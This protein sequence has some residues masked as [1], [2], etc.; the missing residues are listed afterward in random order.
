MAIWRLPPAGSGVSAR[1]LTRRLA[2]EGCHEVLLESGPR[3]GSALLRAGLVDRVA[4]FVAPKLLGDP[5]L[6]W[7]GD[8]GRASLADAM[9]GR[10]VRVGRAG[11]DAFLLMEIDH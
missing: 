8:L 4:C 10:I 3:L 11:D 9:P 6:A 2:R 1:A 7:C 5:G